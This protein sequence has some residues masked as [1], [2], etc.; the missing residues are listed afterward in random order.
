MAS[1][2]IMVNP[3]DRDKH[4]RDCARKNRSIEECRI[5][6]IIVREYAAMHPK[7]LSQ[8]LEQPQV[9][10]MRTSVAAIT[11]ENVIDHSGYETNRMK[12]AIQHAMFILKGYEQRGG[13]L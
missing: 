5:C 3:K 7:F 13:G 4:V 12:K 1:I 6:T 8:M 10:V 9:P 11:I 2:A